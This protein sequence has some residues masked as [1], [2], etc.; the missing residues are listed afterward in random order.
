MAYVRLSSDDRLLVQ[1]HTDVAASEMAALLQAEWH[2]ARQSLIDGTLNDWIWISEDIL[3][4]DFLLADRVQEW[5]ALATC[6]NWSDGRGRVALIWAS[7]AA[8]GHLPLNFEPHAFAALTNPTGALALEV[9]G[10]RGGGFVPAPTRQPAPL[11]LVTATRESADR[12]YTH[13]ALGSSVRR[14]RR[15]GVN[16]TIRAQCSNHEPLGSVYNQAVKE[17]H[18]NHLVAFV[19][20]DVLLEDWHIAHRLDAALRTYDLVGVAG[21]R[22]RLNGQPAWHFGKF[23]G[24]WSPACDLVG[25]VGHD[26]MHRTDGGRRVRVVSHYGHGHDQVQLL[27]GVFLAMR[28]AT[29]LD[30]AP[31]FDPSLG[32]DFYDLDLCRQAEA[33]GLKCGVWPIALTHMSVGGYNADSWRDAYAKYLAKWGELAPVQT[34]PI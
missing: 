3:P 33:A 29:W 15:A 13:T 18:R 20:D 26:T 7:A 6:A 22:R 2:H 34:A 19:H 9:V 11:L 8:A 10:G 24:G 12:F 31:R 23:V 4:N 21:N 28:G 25:C 5:R 30:T 16:L 32:F 27:D 14:L 17:E 1:V